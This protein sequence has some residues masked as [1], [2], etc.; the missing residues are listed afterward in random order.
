M[1]SPGRTAAG[2]RAGEAAE[3]R[4]GPVNPLDRHPERRG[5]C[6]RGRPRQSQ[7]AAAAS[8]RRTRACARSAR[9]RCRPPARRPGCGH[10]GQAD[11]LGELAVVGLDLAV[12]LLGVLDEIHLVDRQRDVA[13]A[14]QRQQARVAAR[15]RSTPLRASSRITAQSAVEAAVTML[16]VYCSWPGVSATMK[17]RRGGREEA[18]RD[19]D[20]DA[21]LA[22]GRRGRRAA[23]R[24]R[25]RRRRAVAPQSA[26]SAAAGHRGSARLVQQAPD[27]GRLAVVDRAAGDEPQQA[28]SRTA[29]RST[30]PASSSPS[31]RRRRGR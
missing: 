12:T 30:P 16:R 5:L 11:L 29:L 31:R 23:A 20:G 10:V 8:A 26:S 15:L 18:V 24:S 22:L 3:V 17:W 19:V 1:S 4:A 28:L 9:R 13:D 21:L 2:D 7:V 27:Q 14:E 25:A 6:G